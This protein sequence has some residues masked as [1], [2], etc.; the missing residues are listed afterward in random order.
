MSRYS[1][2]GKEEGK[3]KGWTDRFKTLAEASKYIQERWPGVEYRDGE[4]HFHTDYSTYE[5]CGFTFNDIG[6]VVYGDSGDPYARFF[7]FA[8]LDQLVDK[9]Y[10]AVVRITGAED[11]LLYGTDLKKLTKKAEAKLTE[12]EPG[13]AGCTPVNVLIQESI[14]SGTANQRRWMTIMTIKYEDLC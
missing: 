1:I 5:L 9:T 10:R 12:N 8:P 7:E 11:Q 3:G 4:E 13:W 6:K 2:R 14:G